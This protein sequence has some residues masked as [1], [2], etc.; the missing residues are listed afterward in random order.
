M[1]LAN[2]PSEHPFH[3]VK[4]SGNAGSSGP[5][6]PRGPDRCGHGP[7]RL[8]HSART[9]LVGADARL[10][11]RPL[12]RPGP[13]PA[14]RLD[15]AAFLLAPQLLVDSADNDAARSLVRVG[16]VLRSR[17]DGDWRRGAW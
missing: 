17:G 2:E 9:R 1:A 6:L 3:G 8:G 7:D 16:S 12:T 15:S 5:E 4:H 10:G 11:R 13:G 14:Q